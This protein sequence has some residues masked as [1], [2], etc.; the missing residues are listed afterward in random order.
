MPELSLCDTPGFMVGPDSEKTAAVRRGSRLFVTAANLAVPLFA[1]VV[2]KGYGLGAQ[3][4]TGGDFSASAFTVAWPTAEFGPMG[5]EGA[6]RLGF[7]KELDAAP[8][9]AARQALFEK[10]TAGMYETGKAVSVAEVDEIDAVIDPAETRAWIVRGLK[11][12]EG[13]PKP[14][15]RPFVDVW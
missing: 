15:K 10:L 8:D 11:A 2:R 14:A 13:R 7:R 12:C 6:V 5:I 1:V 4:M 3:A 9:E